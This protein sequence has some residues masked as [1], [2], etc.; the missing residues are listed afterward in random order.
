M[1][2]HVRIAIALAALTLSA[3]HLLRVATGAASPG[4]Q[5]EA[6]ARAEDWIW[7]AMVGTVPAI[8]AAETVRRYRRRNNRKKATDGTPRS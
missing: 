6:A 8:G 1:T 3:C 5:A 7:W 4:Q 2:W